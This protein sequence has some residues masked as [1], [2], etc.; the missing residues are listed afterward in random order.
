MQETCTNSTNPPSGRSVF[1]DTSTEPLSVRH[2]HARE[3]TVS[4][5]RILGKVSEACAWNNNKESAGR[6]EP[7]DPGSPETLVVPSGTGECDR[8]PLEKA[9]GAPERQA[10]TR[11]H[12]ETRSEKGVQPQTHSHTRA[13]TAQHEARG[14]HTRVLVATVLTQVLHPLT[15]SLDS[16]TRTVHS[17]NTCVT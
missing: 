12:S 7:R 8:V 1:P 15:L 5:F 6:E 2:T 16:D 13:C 4:S 17:T 9:S 3:G 11:P 14:G 10:V